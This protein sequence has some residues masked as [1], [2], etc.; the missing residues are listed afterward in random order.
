MTSASTL[1]FLTLD[2]PILHWPT[3]DTTDQFAR[4]LGF[5]AK[6]DIQKFHYRTQVT[7]PFI[8]DND[9]FVEPQSAGEASAF[10]AHANSWAL[11]GYFKYDIFDKE[12]HL[13]PFF[14]GTYLGTQKVLSVGTGFSWQPKA[15]VWCRE[16]P[17]DGVCAPGDRNVDDL[18]FVAV[19][20]FLDLPIDQ[21]AITAYTVYYYQDFGPG[22]LRNVGVANLTAGGS[23]RGPGNS[24]PSIGTGHHVYGQAGYLLPVRPFGRHKITPYFAIVSSFLDALDEPSLLYQVGAKYYFVGHHSSVALQWQNRPVFGAARGR[25]EDVVFVPSAHEQARASDFILQLM[26]YL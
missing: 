21:G 23:G 12:N 11:A 16:A 18:L 25:F 10:N 17:S 15:V 7:R 22:Y 19:D 1:N 20:G 2:A 5:Y 24:Y 6:G 4:Q 26:V 13:L 9:D 14:V 3:L 8:R